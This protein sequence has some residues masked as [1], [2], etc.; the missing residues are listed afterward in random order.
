[1]K[2]WG[3]RLF[4]GLIVL[5]AI[6]GGLYYKTMRDLGFY[7]TPIYETSAPTLPALPRPALLVFSKT[8]GFIHKD[9]I[10]AAKILLQQIAEQHGWSLYV[11]DNGAIHNTDD[12][13]KFDAVIW[14][15]VSGD[16][17]THEQRLALQHYIENGGGFV[18]LHAT[19]GDPSY[20]WSWQPNTLI[21]AQFIGHPFHPQFQTATVHI[22]DRSDPIM[23]GFGS[24][25]QREDEWYS[26][27][28]SPRGAG[29]HVL[30]TLDE[31][32]YSPEFFGKSIR[33]G[34]D[35]PIIWKHCIAN[36]RV[37]YSA[38]GHTAATYREPQ[39]RSILEHAIAWA[40]AQEGSRCVEGTEKTQ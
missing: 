13:A 4:L 39:Y 20:A 30:A 28:H 5:A 16:V 37:F 17:L 19:G 27:T 22:E 23:Q 7:R 8:N 1:M 25:W 35:H 32:S 34:S 40:S 11:T 10:P 36:G 15:N 14:N 6:G 3:L 9:A 33:M 26:F 31:N 12:L 21:K 38:L 24:T 18:G 29:V 2:K